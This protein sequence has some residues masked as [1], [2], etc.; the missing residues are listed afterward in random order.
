[1][2]ARAPV[3]L[4]IYNRPEHTWRTLEAFSQNRLAAESPLYVF[5]DG[6][7]PDA[8]P[9]ERERIDATRDLVCSRP[10]TRKVTLVESA[11][12]RG[13]AE[14]IVS[15]V[16]RVLDEH[17]RVIVL[18]DDMIT[19]PGFLEY[20]NQALEVYADEP[21]VMHVSGY[22]YP[23]EL[24][25]RD[26]VF[27]RVLSCWGWGTWAR[28]WRH[29]EPDVAK[30]LKF[31]TPERVRKFNV[32][33]HAD[34]YRQLQ[35]N[36]SGR[37]RTWAVRWYASWLAHDGISLFPTKSLVQNIG[38]DGTGV[39]CGPS[40]QFDTPLADSIPVRRKPI[41][42]SQSVRWRINEFYRSGRVDRSVPRI[43]FNSRLVLP[44]RR[45]LVGA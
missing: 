2:I 24:R 33:G 23:L 39:N 12:N 27:L 7:K 13:L 15:G 45:R 8:T 1:M 42:E 10:W 9:A 28:A 36:A 14:S 3:A 19:S 37:M 44:L 18:E 40:R 26:T 16:R 38:H 4:F 21:R 32:E 29:Y 31:V 34:F 22:M 43:W 35:E 5:A 17:S 11:S 30:H 20:M 25:D 41:R 6:P